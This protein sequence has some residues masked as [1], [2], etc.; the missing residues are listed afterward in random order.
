[1][2]GQLTDAGD[3]V[4]RVS[5]GSLFSRVFLVTIHDSIRMVEQ[6]V[7]AFAGLPLS[8]TNGRVYM[9]LYSLLVP[10]KLDGV[11]TEYP[12][13]KAL[14]FRFGSMKIAVYDYDEFI[15]PPAAD[16]IRGS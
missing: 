5:L 16:N 2:G 8:H 3:V 10:A 1:M 11:F 4:R 14:D 7:C 6:F 13:P 9:N 12:L 15:S